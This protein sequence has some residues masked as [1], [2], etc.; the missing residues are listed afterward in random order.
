[1]IEEIIHKKKIFAF[2][3]KGKKYKKKRHGAHEPRGGK[4][5]YSSTTSGWSKQGKTA[6]YKTKA[7]PQKSS[8]RK[9]GGDYPQPYGPTITH[10]PKKRASS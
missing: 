4:P 9:A 5:E 2:I 8:R 7:S 1:M 3:V 6:T 10:H